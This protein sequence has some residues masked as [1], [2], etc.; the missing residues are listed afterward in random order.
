MNELKTRIIVLILPFLLFACAST[1]HL[2]K[3]SPPRFA[4]ITLT[5]RVDIKGAIA[6][7]LEPTTTFN[8]QDSEVIA[9]LKFEN[10]SGKHRLKWDW[11]D[12]SGNLYYST[13][14]FSFKTSSGKYV[15]EVTAWHRLSIQGDKAAE[16]AGQWEVKIF[17]DNEFLESGLFVLKAPIDVAMLP[18]TMQKPY[19]KDWGLVIGIED[20]ADL[21]HVEYARRDALI[22]KEYFVKIMGVPEENIIF[23]TNSNATKARI[24]GYLKEYLP[25]NVGKDTT[26]YVYFAG[27]G[28]SDMKKGD[29]YL[30]LYDGDTRFIAQTGYKL[31]DFYQDLDDLNIQKV[32]VF[33]DSCFSG[34]ASRAAEMLTKGARPA[35]IHAEDVHL[36]SDEIVSISAATAEQTSNAYP[37]AKHGL[38]TYFLLRALK[39]E[40]DANDD[41]W[42]SVKEIFEYVE[43]HVVRV[44]RKMG[45]EQTPTITPSLDTLKDIGISRVLR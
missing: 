31:K 37:A 12:P 5:K 2:E 35:L 3:L 42:I 39:G 26:L 23:L 41:R 15:R 24:E 43:N 44:S 40:A 8:T 36:D 28:I 25:A 27:H 20:Y 7:P 17:I 10:L 4:G 18:E 34:V 14:N 38:F 33:L 32:Y 11:Y 29:P 16:Y 6:I 45:T 30:V 1:R 9:H 13:G 21:P 19:P 22:V